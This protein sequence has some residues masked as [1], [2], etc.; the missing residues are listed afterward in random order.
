MNKTTA[1]AFPILAE[2]DRNVCFSRNALEDTSQSSSVAA[3]PVKREDEK[4]QE[5]RGRERERTQ[6]ASSPLRHLLTELQRRVFFFL[7]CIARM[8]RDTRHPAACSGLCSVGSRV[9][10]KNLQKTR[11]HRAIKE[12]ERGKRVGTR[13]RSSRFDSASSF[14]IA[15]IYSKKKKTTNI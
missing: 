2:F 11:T 13:E 4:L 1:N 8:S 12:K 14:Y 10:N 3:S 15:N 5:T 9:P 6:T 7:C